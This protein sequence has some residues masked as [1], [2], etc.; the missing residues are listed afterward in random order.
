M[1]RLVLEYFNPR[2][3]F[4]VKRLVVNCD[5]PDILQNPNS[6]THFNHYSDYYE[7]WKKHRDMWGYMVCE[8][9]NLSVRNIKQFKEHIQLNHL[10]SKRF[11]HCYNDTLEKEDSFQC[12]QCNVIYQTMKDLTRHT[13]LVH[14]EKS[15]NCLL[16]NEV[17]TRKD[18]LQRHMQTIHGQ[19]VSSLTCQECGKSFSRNDKLKIH[20][21]TVH[22][23]APKFVCE[24]CNTSFN[25]KTNL[26]RHIKSSL[27]SDGMEHLKTYVKNV[28]NS[29]VL[30]NC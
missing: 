11:F 10:L 25:V 19:D 4:E 17:F 23:S 18:N 29:F 6:E 1:K 5:P 30:E 15:Y 2:D 14:F 8:E 13:L 21:S 9:C 3:H 27:N 22:E 26:Q 24:K 20:M 16:C 7:Q 12:D 28:M